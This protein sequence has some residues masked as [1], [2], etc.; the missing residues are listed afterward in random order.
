MYFDPRFKKNCRRT[1]SHGTAEQLGV[2]QRLSPLRPRVLVQYMFDMNLPIFEV[3]NF[4]LLAL[5]YQKMVPNCNWV[6]V[7]SMR[8]TKNLGDVYY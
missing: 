7:L 3:P 1:Q 4:E 8:G 5:G 2:G 6:S